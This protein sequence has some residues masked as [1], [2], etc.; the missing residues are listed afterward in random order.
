MHIPNHLIHGLN[1]SNRPFVVY[2]HDDGNFKCGYVL[3][4]DEF[5]ASITSLTELAE[6][7]GMQ[8]VES[9]HFPI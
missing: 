7:A 3:K 9:R 6:A 1:E 5:I 2:R 8:I 4:S